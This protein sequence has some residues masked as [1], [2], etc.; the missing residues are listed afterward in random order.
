MPEMI[1]IGLIFITIMLAFIAALIIPGRKALEKDEIPKY[2][3]GRSNAVYALGFLVIIL[4]LM[5]IGYISFNVGDMLLGI[6]NTIIFLIVGVGIITTNRSLISLM[7][8]RAEE[9][10]VRSTPFPA[11]EPE[12][13]VLTGS[14]PAQTAYSPQTQA[15]RTPAQPVSDDIRVQVRLPIA[16]GG[17]QPE[18][19]M[20]PPSAAKSTMKLA[21]PKCRGVIVVDRNSGSGVIQCTHC[22]FTG[23]VG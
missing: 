22:G 2:G 4:T 18:Q 21:C 1:E 17:A 11:V 9:G 12:T 15:M 14:A 16:Q 13:E 10:M 20:P 8:D 19:V 6:V 7:K 3:S 5:Y 23:R